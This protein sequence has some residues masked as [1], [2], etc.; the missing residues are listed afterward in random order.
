MTVI[1]N[2]E[3]KY[4]FT[5]LET[6]ETT[7]NWDYKK[8]RYPDG[9]NDSVEDMIEPIEAFVL[10]LL[11]EFVWSPYIPVYGTGALDYLNEQTGGQ[12]KLVSQSIEERDMEDRV[13]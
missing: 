11:D 8:G 9:E 2:K 1:E 10:R 7:F 5:I 6:G 3:G 4:Q 12:F 13:Y